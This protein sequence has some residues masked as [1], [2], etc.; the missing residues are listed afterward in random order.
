MLPRSGSPATTPALAVKHLGTFVFPRTPFPFLD[1]PPPYTA[2]GAPSDPLDI[3]A[4]ILLPARFLPLTR[5]AR[6]RIWGGAL[7]PSVPVLSGAQR[8]LCAQ[9]SGTHPQYGR[10]W[11]DEV[12][13]GVAAVVFDEAENRLHA[14]KSILA[15]CFG[16]PR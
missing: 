8:Q 10:P 14:Q 15:W 12:R 11:P 3:R 7:I 5:P 2:S 1:F 16:A 9:F 13:A 6:P 4:T